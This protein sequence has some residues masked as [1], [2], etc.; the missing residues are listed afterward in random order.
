MDSTLI[1]V[2][3][4]AAIVNMIHLTSS[5]VRSL[6]WQNFFGNVLLQNLRTPHLHPVLSRVQQ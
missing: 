5:F 3:S 4:Q 2:V 1:Y 6:Q